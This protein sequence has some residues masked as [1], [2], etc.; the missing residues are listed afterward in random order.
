[1]IDINLAFLL[2]SQ[3]NV[4]KLLT[5]QDVLRKGEFIY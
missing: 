3:L 4:F 2:L 5:W 1:M